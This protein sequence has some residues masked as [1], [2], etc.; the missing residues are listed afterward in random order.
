MIELVL[1]H[2]SSLYFRREKKR[3]CWHLEAKLAPKDFSFPPWVEI[4]GLWRRAA[5]GQGEL[6]CHCPGGAH[7]VFSVP[8]KS[9]TKEV[10]KNFLAGLRL[11]LEEEKGVINA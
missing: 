11:L 4:K 1:E 7:L 5:P 3:S 9:M 6:L 2:R 8:V 10:K